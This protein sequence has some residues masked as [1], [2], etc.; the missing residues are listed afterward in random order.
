MKNYQERIEEIARKTKSTR[1][2]R[3][4]QNADLRCSHLGLRTI[5]LEHGIDPYELSPGEFIVFANKK[6]NKLKIYAPGNVIA[7]VKPPNDQRIDLN[8]I[9]LIPRFFNGSEFNY[10]SALRKHFELKFK[11]AA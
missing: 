1:V 10:D 3:F 7:Y 8:V 2:I 9:R 4:F 11:K 6:I 5:A